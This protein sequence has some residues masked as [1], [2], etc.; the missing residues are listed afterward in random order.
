MKVIVLPPA[1]RDLDEA[2][3]F[4]E[5]QSRGLGGYFVSSVLADFRVLSG[6][7]GTHRRIY[8]A[9]RLL[10]RRFPYAI[11]YA[12]EDGVVSVLA[13]LDCRMDPRRMAERLRSS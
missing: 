5:E 1:R 13:V 8:G 4:Y 12:V 6:T 2:Y 10:T 3:S 11:F 7:A 9:H